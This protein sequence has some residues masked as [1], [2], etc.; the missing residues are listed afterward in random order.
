[1]AALVLTSCAP[2]T[3]GS[4]TTDAGPSGPT[5]TCEI[6]SCRSASP[7]RPANIYTVIETLLEG[8]QGH[9][10]PGATYVGDMPVHQSAFWETP[11]IGFTRAKSE[12][13]CL[14]DFHFP[15]ANSAPLETI[16]ADQ[17]A[18]ME[19]WS[20]EGGT[21]PKASGVVLACKS[22][23]QLEA[24]INAALTAGVNVITVDSDSAASNRLLYLGALNRPAG[25]SAGETMLGLL[26][27]TTGK[28]VILAASQ[29]TANVAERV[30]GITDAFTAAGRAADLD[31]RFELSPDAIPATLD[32][33]R[34]THGADLRGVIAVQGSFSALVGDWIANN[35]L[36]SQV[37]AVTWDTASAVLTHIRNAVINATMAQKSYFYG[38][39]PVYI[40]YAMTALG[41]D[42]TMALLAPYLSGANGDLLDTGMDVITPTNIQEYE[43]YQLECLGVTAG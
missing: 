39:L 34:T 8:L 42:Q 23:T 4:T 24:P 17:V 37:K 9:G 3:T 27:T 21:F 14:G 31:V 7:A 33:A 10:D 26:G 22:S 36:Q 35:A 32:A 1:V 41:P 5:Y 28:V 40:L 19:D 2:T 12:L 25:V 29:Q 18:T 11:R 16:I 38:Y 6:C 13:G 30:Q 15:P 20:S 43:A